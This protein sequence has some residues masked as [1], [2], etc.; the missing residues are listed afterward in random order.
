MLGLLRELPFISG[1]PSCGLPPEGAEPQEAIL[2]GGEG[3]FH[4]HY[5]LRTKSILKASNTDSNF[6]TNAVI[7]IQWVVAVGSRSKD[8]RRL[9]EVTPAER[10]PADHSGRENRH[11]GVVEVLL[12]AFEVS[13]A[14]EVRS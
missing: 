5:A 8:S 3:R 2:L 14:P 9:L 6:A 13:N 1:L 12:C 10:V 4:T 7:Q 11:S